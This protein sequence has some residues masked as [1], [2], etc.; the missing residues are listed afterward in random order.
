MYP[1]MQTQWPQQRMCKP[2]TTAFT[3]WEGDRYPASHSEQ[4]YLGSWVSS[5][6][7]AYEP[8]LREGIGRP[9][10]CFLQAFVTV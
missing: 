10:D 1:D 6:G 3:F 5:R 9:E 7:V 2:N 4:R 8:G